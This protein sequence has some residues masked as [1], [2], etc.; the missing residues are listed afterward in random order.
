MR[1]PL[2]RRS[3]RAGAVSAAALA[4]S[5]VLTSMLAFAGLGGLGAPSAGAASALAST[6]ALDSQSPAVVTNATGLSLE[7]VV[8]STLA[9]PQLGIAV[10]LFSKAQFLDTFR[11][12]LTGNTAGLSVMS[13][14]GGSLPLTTFE[15]SAAGGIFQIRLPVSAPDLP[16]KTGPAPKNG[17][18]LQVMCA[19]GSCAGVYP[20]QVSLTN[21]N[22]GITLD[23]FTTYLVLAPPSETAQTTP[24]RFAW[25]MT[26]G[27]NPAITPQGAGRPA[28]TDLSELQTLAGVIGSSTGIPATFNLVPQFVEGLT[29][30]KRSKASATAL[31][32]LRG[33]ATS[34][35]TEIIPDTFAS[36]DLPA[37][38]NSGL[39][40]DTAAQLLEGRRVLQDD[41][42]TTGRANEFAA[43][44]AIGPRTLSLLAD[45]G[46]N[47]LVVPS[48]GVPLVAPAEQV[49]AALSP[50]L[51][52]HSGV[53]AVASDAG[54]E[55]H[56]S[57][58]G[59]SVLRANQLLANLAELYFQVPTA[60]KGAALLC[61]AGWAPTPAFLDTMA[62]G[63]A[64][65]ALVKA[66]TLS[67]LLSSVPP[68]AASPN[69]GVLRTRPIASGTIASSRLLPAREIDAA[70]V[71]LHAVSA[72]MPSATATI[73]RL[74]DSLY[75]AETSGMSP[76][77]RRAY[78]Q[79]ISG[80]LGRIA[81]LISLPFGHTITVT[82]LEAKVPI[83]IVSHA[84]VPLT[85]ELSASSPD[86]GFGAHH[87]WTVR[88]LPRTNIV[89]I[90]LTARTSGDFPLDL[91][92]LS[93]GGAAVL[94]AGQLTIRSTAISG[95]AVGISIGALVF[96]VL[97]WTRSIVQR[98][99]KVHRRR[100]A[101]LAASVAGG[102]PGSD[103]PSAR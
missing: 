97:W 48:N 87:T 77:T 51:V 88:L 54:L 7:V 69:P 96:L 15:K 49:Y 89:M 80:A 24:L 92:V 13:G 94:L 57:G 56:L 34:P 4:A 2:T 37:L 21:L 75:M 65:N 43:T 72:S 9:A 78:L 67:S 23:T 42:G 61:P 84:A 62:S 81:R 3:R 41:L 90:E 71:Q 103:G 102:G 53:E 93:P 30:S 5:T 44:T 47:A 58:S 25:V 83:S 59:N 79:S 27:A 64:S 52:A 18:D 40:S 100:G 33:F 6:L 82:S 86:L 8:R 46:V 95:V 66:S 10:T 20:L 22:E 68:G 63:L 31:G 60:R 73:R 11:Q 26:L 101:E 19:P 14:T 55:S 50:F 17:A 35:T 39:G 70:R 76:G 28:A 85:V 1:A 45:N 12:T 29:L 74:T 91:E 36:V 32:I 16:G 38:G 98:R 99:R